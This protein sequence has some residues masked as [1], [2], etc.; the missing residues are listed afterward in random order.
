MFVLQLCAVI[1][2]S[3][4]QAEV[5]PR[6]EASGIPSPGVSMVLWSSSEPRQLSQG[7]V[8]PDEVEDVQL[9]MMKNATL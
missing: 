6:L 4:L 5:W 1:G 2:G 7:S 3:K 9:V 8:F